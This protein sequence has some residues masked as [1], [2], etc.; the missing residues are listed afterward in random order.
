I[1]R[2][3]HEA[4]SMSQALADLRRQVNEFSHDVEY[5]ETTKDIEYLMY[6]PSTITVGRRGILQSRTKESKRD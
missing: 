1:N 2:L 3:E 4:S 6:T 5:V